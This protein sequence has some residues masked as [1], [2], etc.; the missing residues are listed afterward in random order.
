[1]VFDIGFFTYLTAS[2]SFTVLGVLLVAYRRVKSL[3]PTLFLACVVTAL[4]A[5]LIAFIP[6]VDALVSTGLV[7]FTELTRNGCWLFFLLQ[8]LGL[9]SDGDAWVIR[10]R[11]WRQLFVP[12]F[13][14]F[15]AVPIAYGMLPLSEAVSSVLY[16]MSVVVLLMLSL[17][18][19]LLIEQLFRNGS[20]GE[21]WSLKYLCFGLGSVFAY[22]FFMYSEAFLFR[23]M[24]TE[25]WQ[26]RGLVNAL[27]APLLAVTIARSSHWRINLHV[28]RE[29]V[30]HSV[31]LMGA[32]VYLLGMAV[33]GY[34]I[35]YLGGTWGG[36]L[37]FGFLAAAGLLLLILLFSGKLRAQM[38]VLLSK[39]F[40]SYRYDYREEWLKFTL[41]LA[42]LNHSVAEGI[43]RIMAPLVS[44]P[45]G[46][47]WACEEGD[48]MHLL[49]HWEMPPPQGAAEGLGQLPAWLQDTDWVI[50]LEEWRRTPNSYGAL[51]LPLWLQQERALWLIVPLVFRDRLEAILM[52][53]RSSLKHSINWEDRDLLKTAGR[54]AATHLAQHLASKALVEARQF[55]AFNRLSAYVV[56]DLKNILAQQSLMLSNAVKHRNNPAFVDD[57]IATVENSVARMQRL[58]EQM[59]SGVRSTA[60]GNVLLAS[61]LREVIS[62]RSTVLP[63]PQALF[64]TEVDVSEG[65]RVAAGLEECAVEADPERLGT[66]FSHLIQNAQEATDAQGTVTARLRRD[67]DLAIIDIEDT[68]RGM[69][70]D[71]IRDRL[72]HPFESTKGLTGMGIGTF[73]SRDYIRQL[74]GDIRVESTPGKGSVF[75]VIIP[76]IKSAEITVDA[77]TDARPARWRSDNDRCLSQRETAMPY[78]KVAAVNCHE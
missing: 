63:V 19:L 46:L 33:A 34:F 62:A 3:G 29:M 23:A 40:F 8:L 21:R 52:L 7:Q 44:S 69:D 37:Q 2:A 56:H 4:W 50:D 38:R 25:L 49:A 57:M 73:E 13:I 65:S 47:L 77:A 24:D 28:S 67:R 36:V 61:L 11:Q 16:Q 20:Q 70:A 42:S 43:I 6:P 31:T 26:A 59:R 45:A 5:G 27:A 10:G 75:H 64:S 60:G 1:M 9:Q 35:K 15:A 74:G 18:G 30:F 68:G 66:V 22:D 72:F 71:F 32:G 53:K 12:V 39:H 14:C 78:K 76:L 17:F 54:Q 55:D 51:S 58:M 41:A 48:K